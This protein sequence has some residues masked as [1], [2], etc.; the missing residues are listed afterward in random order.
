M[1]LFRSEEHARSWDRYDD[2]M[3]ASLRP[4]AEWANIFSNVYFRARSRPDFLSWAQSEPGMEAFAE[5]RRRAQ[6]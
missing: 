2:T 6:S 3:A 4:V 1:N 5:L